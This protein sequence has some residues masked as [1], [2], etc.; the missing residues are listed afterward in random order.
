MN[1]IGG[2]LRVECGG[3]NGM[4]VVRKDLQSRRDIG[5]VVFAGFEGN[6]QVGANKSG[7]EFRNQFFD[8]I[9][10]AAETVTAEIAVKGRFVRSPVR[11]FV[12]DG[13]VIAVRVTET[14]EGRK[15]DGVIAGAV[16]SAVSAVVDGRSDRG[17]KLLGMLDAS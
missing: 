5:G 17:K 8:R 1:E 6:F 15:L 10:F 13:G 4:R 14:L 2:T 11:Q 3:E 16:E 12:G 7:A 9:G